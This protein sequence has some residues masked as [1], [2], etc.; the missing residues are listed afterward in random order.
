MNF[1][2]SLG[3]ALIV[4]GVLIIFHEFG[5]FLA[6]R[7]TGVKVEKFSIGFGPE[8]LHW[9]GKET[10]YSVSVF[11]LG[12]FVKPA[13][14]SVSEVGEGGP[15]AG[16]YLAAPL[17][18]RMFIIVSG[19]AMNYL[20]AYGLFVFL[21][22]LG[23]PVPGTTVGGFVDGYPAIESGLAAGDKIM[24]VD[25]QPVRTWEQLTAAFDG[26]RGETM[27]LTVDRGGVSVPVVLRPKIQEARDLAGNTVT[28]RRIGIIPSPEAAEYERYGLMESL[29]TAGRA[30]VSLTVLTYRGI[31]GLVSGKISMKNVAGP[32]G[33][34]NLTGTAAQMGLPH[35]LQL[36]AI[37]SISLAVINLLPIPALD[38]GHLL[39]L[40]IEAVRR[41]RLSLQFQER[42]TQAGFIALLILMV[43]ILYND[44]ANIQVVEKVKSIFQP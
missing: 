21:F 40:L 3:P 19:V 15:Q 6:C 29:V 20:L 8:I 28:V 16:D 30:T 13:G 41:K 42:A 25:R 5:H 39:F 33:I 9:Q 37:L 14:E 32:V 11:P 4:L 10:R 31:W 2:M 17:G 35:V 38:G 22:V 43:F 27:M 18:S 23:R 34:I 26:V 7:L 1:L 44:L 36:T 24:A 12:G